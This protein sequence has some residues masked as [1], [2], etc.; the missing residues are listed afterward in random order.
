M[1]RRLGHGMYIFSPERKLRVLEELLAE[2]GKVSS[3]L[4]EV[5]L[6][7][8]VRFLAT[9]FQLLALSGSEENPFLSF[10]G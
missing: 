9:C 1:H 5:E 3:I 4:D 8:D 10:W 2:D 7:N 6:K